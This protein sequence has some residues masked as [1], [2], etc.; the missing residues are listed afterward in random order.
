MDSS[1]KK[2]ELSATSFILPV[3]LVIVT[4]SLQQALSFSQ[5]CLAFN[6]FWLHQT[7]VQ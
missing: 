1:G 4:S 7:A 2:Y 6:Q 3:L 5:Q